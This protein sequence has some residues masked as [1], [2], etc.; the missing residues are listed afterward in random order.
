MGY[1]PYR[2]ETAP[3][4]GLKPD[5]PLGGKLVFGQHRFLVAYYGTAQTGSMGVL[6][7]TST[8]RRC[9]AGSCAPPSRSASPASRSSR[10]TS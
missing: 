5:L 1:P 3:P 10:S 7:Q 2:V 4:I 8:Q 6:G 9:S